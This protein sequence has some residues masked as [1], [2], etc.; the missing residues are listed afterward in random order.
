MRLKFLQLQNFIWLTST[1]ANSSA[2]EFRIEINSDP[3]LLKPSFS[4]HP[5]NPFIHISV[6]LSVRPSVHLSIHPFIHPSIYLNWLHKAFI[7]KSLS[8]QVFHVDKDFRYIGRGLLYKGYFS[9]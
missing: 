8:F 5:S 6:R 4:I 2:Y 9:P 1:I 3:L 7:F